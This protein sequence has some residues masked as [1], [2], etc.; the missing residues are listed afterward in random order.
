MIV[1]IIRHIFQQ[2]LGLIVDDIFPRHVCHV[3]IE[4]H[5]QP[6]NTGVKGNACGITNGLVAVA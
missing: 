4:N 1:R 6:P 5:R 2:H 3:I